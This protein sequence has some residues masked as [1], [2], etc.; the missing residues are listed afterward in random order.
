MLLVG[1]FF[2]RAGG[3][4]LVGLV[5]AVALAATTAAGEFETTTVHETPESAV[6]SRT[7]T[8][9]RAVSRSST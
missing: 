7:T 4:I 6:A 3:L 2:G 1:A 9:S 5:S 8:R